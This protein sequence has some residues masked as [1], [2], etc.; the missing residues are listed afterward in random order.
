MHRRKVFDEAS[1]TEIFCSGNHFQFSNT[2]WLALF[3]ILSY[4]KMWFSWIILQLKTP[5]LIGGGSCNFQPSFR[6]GSVSF[7]P[8]GGGGPCDFL[9]T[10]FPN[11]PAH[12]TLYFLTS[13]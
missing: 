2:I 5:C 6:D 12:P 1:K 11:A 7:M 4:K 13:P 10:T 3:M 8:K 9:S